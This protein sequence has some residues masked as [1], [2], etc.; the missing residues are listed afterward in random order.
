MQ[1]INTTKQLLNLIEN[2]VPQKLLGLQ[3]L[4]STSQYSQTKHRHKQRQSGIP[5]LLER[6]LMKALQFHIS[7]TKGYAINMLLHSAYWPHAIT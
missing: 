7:H 3:R 4:V 5:K 6:F 2:K 1:P